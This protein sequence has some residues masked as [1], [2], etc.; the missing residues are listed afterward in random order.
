[1][2]AAVHPLTHPS[3]KL[4]RAEAAENDARSDETTTP[5]PATTPRVPEAQAADSLIA[6]L[7]AEADEETAGA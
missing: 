5:E 3:A 4:S 6:A 7:A 2:N 1:M